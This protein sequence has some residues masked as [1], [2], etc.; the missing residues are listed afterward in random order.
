M[1]SESKEMKNA[2][3]GKLSQWKMKETLIKKILFAP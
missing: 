3:S 2:E 1:E